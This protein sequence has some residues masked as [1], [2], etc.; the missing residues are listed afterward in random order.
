[1][2]ASRA[3]AEA[4]DIVTGHPRLELAIGDLYSPQWPHPITMPYSAYH[5]M[6][7]EQ[8]RLPPR[9]CAGVL[10]VWRVQ[11][12]RTTVRCSGTRTRAT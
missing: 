10:V 12:A 7:P 3:R 6:D 1:M 8:A 2:K 5:C 11:V 4:P 9:Q